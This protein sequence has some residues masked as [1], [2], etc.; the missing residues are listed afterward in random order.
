MSRKT[1]LHWLVSFLVGATVY[2]AS[3]RLGYIS[4]AT[5]FARYPELRIA[6]L[7]FS[8]IIAILIFLFVHSF[9][10]STFLQVENSHR[11]VKLVPWTAVISVL[12]ISLHMGYSSLSLIMKN[13][14][15]NWE[16]IE[17]ATPL[18]VEYDFVN[19]FDSD[20][21]IGCENCERIRSELITIDGDRKTSL[22]MHP[23][24]RVS[25]Q[26][27]PPANSKLTFS[28]ALAPDVWQI[29]LGDGVE[30]ELFIDNGE[31][32][33]KVFTK[34]I[35]PKNVK[36]HRAWI[37][38][39]VDLSEWAGQSVV[40]IFSTAPGPNADERYDWAE[41]GEPRVV[42][43]VRYDFLEKF[44]QARI[45]ISD[46]VM[47]QVEVTTL[48]I[49]NEKRKILFLHPSSRVIYSL[50]LPQNHPSLR[51]G[52]GM[53]EETWSPEKGDGVVYNIYVRDLANPDV[54]HRVFNRMI[55]P[56][57]NPDDRRWFNEAVDLEKFSGLN[58]EIIFEA[59]PGLEGNNDFD[60]GGISSPVLV[61]GFTELD[62]LE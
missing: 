50:S 6:T 45:E 46:E 29:G 19:L 54:L 15:S 11:V 31:V 30:F 59:L 28:L 13:N 17:V 53:A 40:L 36:D 33:K 55:D 14:A 18:H 43:P 35:D 4:M 2:V 49:N 24:S 56:K 23:S 61:S 5:N 32:I 20:S 37:D 62:S 12:L 39:E 22:F 58:V 34:Y 3:S 7:E 16:S 38:Y 48:T 9:L 25:Y 60:W 27:V 47:T 52:L 21:R 57:N 8:L 10:Q 44:S 42:L 41:W 26:V 51:F 1:I